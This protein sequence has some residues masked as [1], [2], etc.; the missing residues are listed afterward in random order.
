MAPE[1]LRRTGHGKA[2]DLWSI[3]VLSYFLLCGYTPFDDRN[4]GLETHKIC[5]SEYEFQEEYWAGISET[6]KDFIRSLLVVEP[7]KRLTATQA[8]KHDWILKDNL[9]DVNLL[10]VAKRIFNARSAFKKAVGKVKV[11]NMMSKPSTPTDGVPRMS[12]D[13]FS[14][15]YNPIEESTEMVWEKHA[16]K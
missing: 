4:P 15:L 2:V 10:P 6:A 3:G 7:S 14:T 13:E 11:V 8:L 9:N 16:K 12:I 5:H 1:V